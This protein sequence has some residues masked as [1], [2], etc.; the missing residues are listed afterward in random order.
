MIAVGVKRFH[1]GEVRFALVLFS[2]TIDM[3]VVKNLYQE[4]ANISEQT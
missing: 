2:M 3:I 1:Q 4:W